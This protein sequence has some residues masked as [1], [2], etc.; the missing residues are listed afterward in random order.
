MTKEQLDELSLIKE[1]VSYTG[2][3]WYDNSVILEGRPSS[4]CAILWKSTILA[5]VVPLSVNSRR[6]CAV[7]VCSSHWKLLLV[8]VYMPYEND[9]VSTKNLHSYFLYLMI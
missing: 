9:S 5:N 3:S 4:G 8:N 1:N 6:I 2:V 7:R